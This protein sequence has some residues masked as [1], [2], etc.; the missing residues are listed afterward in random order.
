VDLGPT[1]I[2]AQHH[3]H[4]H[5]HRRRRHHHQHYHQQHHVRLI[6]SRQ[7]ATEQS[8]YQVAF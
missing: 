6:A 1:A 4:H 8:V 3:R 7:N 2:S 5:R